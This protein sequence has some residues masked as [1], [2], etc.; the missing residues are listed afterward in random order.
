MTRATHRGRVRLQSYV[1]P[2]FADRV[3]QYCLAM[4][5]SESAIVK[6]SLDQYLGTTADAKVLLRRLDRLGRAVA[7]SQRDLQLLSHAFGVF[8]RLWLAHTPRLQE[9]AKP[10]AR[11]DA[12][13]RYRQFVEHV[14][15]EFSGGRRFLDDLSREVVADDAELDA[16]VD[17]SNGS[18]DKSGQKLG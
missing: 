16:L 1:E 8:T 9:E 6:S 17:N 4:G 13:S 5:V 11:V 2:A 18:S 10:G 12:E 3:N 15:E 14:S 7:R